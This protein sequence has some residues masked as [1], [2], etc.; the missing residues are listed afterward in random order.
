MRLNEPS[1][2][3]T[4]KPRLMEQ[5]NYEITPRFKEIVADTSK[6]SEDLREIQ[7]TVQNY[8]NHT[9]GVPQEVRRI[10]IK[11][12]E[13]LTILLELQKKIQTLELNQ[14]CSSRRKPINFG[15]V[16]FTPKAKEEP[17]KSK[18]ERICQLLRQIKE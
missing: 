7:K 13:I 2:K 16:N 6:I 15:K 11:Q 1:T 5:R 10:S 8:G 9:Y 12:D 17:K 4:P 3:G 14:T 18:D